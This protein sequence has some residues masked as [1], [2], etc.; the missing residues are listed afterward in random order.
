MSV[1][2][3][4]VLLV[5][6]VVLVLLR[7]RSR[8]R[9]RRRRWLW[10][11]AGQRREQA[12]R[13]GKDRIG[14]R[15]VEPACVARLDGR[16]DQLPELTACLPRLVVDD[17]TVDVVLKQAKAKAKEIADAAKTGEWKPDPGKICDL[18]ASLAPRPKDDKGP[19]LSDALRRLDPD[20]LQEVQRIVAPDKA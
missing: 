4:L 8:S 19:R 15:G 17:R 11:G 14:L 2:V 13:G 3:V 12:G 5:A 16:V 1:T 18:I 9:G 20:D 10:P 7:L 6:L